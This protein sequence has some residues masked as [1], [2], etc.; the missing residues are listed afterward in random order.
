MHIKMS[1]GIKRE[2]RKQIGKVYRGEN[3]DAK[4]DFQSS[5][6]RICIEQKYI[7]GIRMDITASGKPVFHVICP[8]VTLS[9]AYFYDNRHPRFLEVLAI[10]VSSIVLVLTFLSDFTPYPEMLKNYLRERL[11]ITRQTDQQSNESIE[12]IELP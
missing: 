5:I 12:L 1:N 10:I 3:P 2:M 6:L 7:D 4:T 11:P 8:H 9:G